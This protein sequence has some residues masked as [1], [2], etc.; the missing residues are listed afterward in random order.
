MLL[1]T[2]LRPVEDDLE[3]LRE[4]ADHCRARACVLAAGDSR[5]SLQEMA[6]ELDRHVFEVERER[7]RARTQL[8]AANDSTALGVLTNRS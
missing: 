5:D 4:L 8:W 7:C 2:L 3:R 6:E 1:T